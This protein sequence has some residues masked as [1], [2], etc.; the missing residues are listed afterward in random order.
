MPVTVHRVSRVRVEPSGIEFDAEAG[1][2]IMAAARHAG[3]EWP[4]LC[5]GNAQCNRCYVVVLAGADNLSPM[6]VVE[7]EGLERVRWADG[8]VPGERLAC[9][10]Q[11]R[12]DIVVHKRGVL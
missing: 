7:R 1:Q 12:G 6:T 2:S 9:Q 11:P 4:T 5:Q 3:Y 10:A 8:L